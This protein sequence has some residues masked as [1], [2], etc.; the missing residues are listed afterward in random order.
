MAQQGNRTYP[1][2]KGDFDSLILNTVSSSLT[3]SRSTR[4]ANDVL[5]PSGTIARRPKS[6]IGR[7]PT[8]L[9]NVR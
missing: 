6:P 9:A 2:A 5:N 8:V 3:N 1:S 4:L 7:Y